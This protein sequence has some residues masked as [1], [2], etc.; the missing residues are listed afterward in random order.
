L[1]P[2]E[3]RNARFVSAR[4]EVHGSSE[5]LAAMI[6]KIESG[7]PFMVVEAA[8]LKPTAGDDAGEKISATL[9]ILGAVGWAEK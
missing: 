1:Q 5:D 7:W 8:T 6:D 4:V 9:D 2:R 3:G